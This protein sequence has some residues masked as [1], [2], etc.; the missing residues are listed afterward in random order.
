MSE[1]NLRFKDADWMTRTRDILQVG[2]GGI[3]RGTAAEL[4]NVGHYLVI[5]EDDVV[6]QHNCIPQGF[7]LRH[8]GLSKFN[9]WA[10][11]MSLKYGYDL[12][13]VEWYNQKYDESGLVYPIMIAAVDNMTTRRV[14]FENWKKQENRELFIDGRMLAEYFEVFA[15]TPKNQDEYEAYLFA[16]EDVMPMP[17]TYQQTAFVANIIHGT[18]CQVVCNYVTG[19]MVPFKTVYNGHMLDYD[20]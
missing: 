3:G 5:Y 16:D 6:E 13:P 17:C 20:N 12:V 8:V 2:L 19:K 14:M 9:A 18:I 7:F 10:D 11:Q 1:L 4:F 15:V